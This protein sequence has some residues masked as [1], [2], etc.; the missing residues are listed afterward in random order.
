M[1]FQWT[2]GQLLR[3]AVS[4]GLLAFPPS[5]CTSTM[6]EFR[7]TGAPA[8]HLSKDDLSLLKIWIDIDLLKHNRISPTG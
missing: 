5:A 6:V 2:V 4:L 8:K 7:D 3:H 1:P